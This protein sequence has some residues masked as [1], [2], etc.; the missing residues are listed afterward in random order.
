MKEKKHYVYIESKQREVALTPSLIMAFNI[1]E[2]F[3]A[4][5]AAGVRGAGSLSVK[6]EEQVFFSSTILCVEK[7]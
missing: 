2:S 4:Y 5:K 6:R 3:P 7:K 1:A